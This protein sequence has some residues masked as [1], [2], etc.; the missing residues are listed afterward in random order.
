[1]AVRNKRGTVYYQPLCR[2]HWAAALRA[3][4]SARKGD[5]YLDCNGYV[6]ARGEDGLMHPE[7]RVVM[8]RMLGRPLQKGE[9]VHHK[10]GIRHDNDPENLELWIGPIRRGARGYDLVCPHCGRGYLS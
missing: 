6:V 5:R 10:N 4:A 3:R 1:M 9:S 8:E 7:H 2:A